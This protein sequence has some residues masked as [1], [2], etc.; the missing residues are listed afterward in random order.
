MIKPL[1]LIVEDEKRLQNLYSDTLTQAN[2]ETLKAISPKEALVILKKTIPD[3]II[4]DVRMPNMDGISFMKL[5]KEDYPTIPFLLI[6]AYADIKTAVEA[7][8]LGAVDYLQKPIDLDELIAAIS[9]IL[10]INNNIKAT[11]IPKELLENI[12][13][14]SPLTLQLYNDAYKIAKSEAGVLIT[15]ESG[16]GKEVLANFIHKASPRCQ[17]DLIVINCAAIPRDLLASEL[18][19]HKKGAFTGAL[20]N[21][22]GKF[23]VADKST[24]FL[25]EIGDMPLDLQPSLLRALEEGTIS[26]VG[27]D[28][29]IS[30]DFRLITATNKN[31][32][33][34][35]EKGNFRE[36]LYY[37]LNVISFELPPLR[38]RAEEI[39]AFAKLFLQKKSS[40]AQ[41]L[42]VSTRK[43]LQNYDWPGNIRELSNAM[44]RAT[45]LSSSD[46]ILP[47]HLPPQI[48]SKRNSLNDTNIG[49]VKTISQAEKEAII[50][51][52]DTTNGN[53]TKA[54]E[55]LGITRRTLITKIKIFNLT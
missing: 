39:P 33:E 12:V 13:T 15:G 8:K 11:I 6:T 26:P 1:I 53:R 35:V 23:L 27:S 7:L 36:D 3:M 24:L 40:Q 52:L 16:T 9:D 41:R 31:L 18:F 49:I 19:G 30:V 44:E 50:S 10:H 21:R 32:L 37:R 28:R 47:E 51:A 20:S 17:N 22:K 5:V 46:I 55:L 14:V 4:S 45:I 38:D 42:S 48:R 43:I 54:A 2:F 25:D 34:E 29:D